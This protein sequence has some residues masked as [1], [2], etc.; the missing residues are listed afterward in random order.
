MKTREKK[1]RRRNGKTKTKYTKRRQA[2]HRRTIQILD[3][4]CPLLIKANKQ[5][6]DILHFCFSYK[7]KTLIVFFF[8]WL[9]SECYPS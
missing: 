3:R 5:K 9:I 6:N 1:T 4:H 2:G 8:T 7:N